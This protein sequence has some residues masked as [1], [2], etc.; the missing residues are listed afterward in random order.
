MKG[1][2]KP[3]ELAKAVP[4]IASENFLFGTGNAIVIESDT[5]LLYYGDY[6]IL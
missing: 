5:V 2:G 6:Y 4:C 3:K 1:G